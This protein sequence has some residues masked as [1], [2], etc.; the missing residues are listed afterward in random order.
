VSLSGYLSDV[1]IAEVDELGE[2]SEEADA[3]VAV[4]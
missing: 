3:V 2:V 1:E 4:G